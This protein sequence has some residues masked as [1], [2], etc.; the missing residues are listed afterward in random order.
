VHECRT[1]CDVFPIS[2]EYSLNQMES[3]V[4]ALGRRLLPSS[5]YERL[6]SSSIARRLARGSL[7]SLFGSATARILV[8]VAMILVARVLGQVS[9]GE[10]GLIQST[11]GMAGLM[12]GMGLGETGTR[13]VAK[14][15]T[16][17][18][19]RA[20]RVIALV[21]SVSVGTVVL[22]TV[23]LIS[24]SG[25]IAGAVLN[26]PR[27]QSALVWGSL[28]M[29]A[30]AFRGIQGGVFAGLERFDALAQLNILDG[31]ASLVAMVFLAHLMGVQGAVLG[32]ALGTI[33]VWLVGRIL[34]K[35]VLTGRGI[36][37]RYRG[38]GA[39]WRILTSYSLPSLLANLV[40]TPVLWFAMTLV[41]R[42]GQGFAGLGLY[43]A[44]YQWQGPMMF[45]PMILLSVSIPVLV[46]E[47]EAGRKERFRTVTGGICALTLAL[48]LPPAVVAALFSPWI[49]SLYGPGFREGWTVL[50][51]LLAAA[52][53]HALTKIVSGALLAMNRAWWVLGL[54]LG[55]S[56]TL[57]AVTGWLVTTRGVLGLAIA[58]LAAY[59]MLG[60]FSLASVLMGSKQR[61]VRDSVSDSV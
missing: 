58:F 39:D 10:L 38:C 29:A 12:A 4:V 42:S 48:S 52:P 25:L 7:W 44:A 41:A 54:N 47:W 17:D 31:V 61:V 43:N 53:L 23:A 26:A 56:A 19:L 60:T 16:S 46:Q 21:T 36:A 5:L 1:F 14:Y 22:A 51:L 20:G 40:A 28:L 55:W 27:L 37:V 3:V 59:A 11:L 24:V 6:A 32:L 8:L 35:K 50:V 34:L 57:L 49:M 45:I 30:T 33:M 18:P 13:F 2:C 15:A 9:F